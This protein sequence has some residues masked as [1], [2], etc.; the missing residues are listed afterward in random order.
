MV[1]DL[2]LAAVEDG[3]EHRTLQR[4]PATV[5]EVDHE[6]R[7]LHGFVLFSLYQ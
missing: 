5:I 1:E 2:L 3:Q 7:C 4:V 6:L